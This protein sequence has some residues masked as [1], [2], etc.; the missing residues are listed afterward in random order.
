MPVG[1]PA[2]PY[3][4]YIASAISPFSEICVSGASTAALVRHGMALVNAPGGFG[5]LVE[6]QLSFQYSCHPGRSEAESRDPAPDPGE[7]FALPE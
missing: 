5:F 6:L 2:T 7:R 3:G 1:N 4:A